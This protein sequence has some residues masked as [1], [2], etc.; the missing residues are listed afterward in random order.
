MAKNQEFINGKPA[1]G[2]TVLEMADELNKQN[3]DF[4]QLYRPFIDDVANLA[5]ENKQAYKLFMF[6]VK[7]MDGVNALCVSN[8]ALMEI[9]QCSQ[10]TVTRS[11]KYL[12]DNGW[13]DVLK[14]GTSN[15]YIINPDVAWTSYANQKEYCKFKSNVI[16]SS[17]ENAEYL[18]NRKA[19][20][21]FKTINDDFIR[22]VQSKNQKKFDAETGEIFEQQ[23]A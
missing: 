15:V 8:L 22:Q 16:L 9:L 5:F 11:V 23:E 1:V 20:T 13:M 7:H 3:K 6:F 14:S 19:T 10:P 18:K 12:K 4:V 21:R 17:S 2:M